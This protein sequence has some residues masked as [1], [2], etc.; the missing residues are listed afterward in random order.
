MYYRNAV[1]INVEQSFLKEQIKCVFVYV[2]DFGFFFHF[3]GLKMFRK[4]SSDSK[5]NGTS[6]QDLFLSQRQ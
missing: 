6:S 3:E 5:K 1:E 2:A 4:N